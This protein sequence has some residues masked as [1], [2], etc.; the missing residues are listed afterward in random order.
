MTCPTQTNN[1]RKTKQNQ[2]QNKPDDSGKTKTDNKEQLKTQKPKTFWR[3]AKAG[4]KENRNESYSN[5]TQ[6]LVFHRL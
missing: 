6:R 1:K 3:A 4:G 2:N 5:I